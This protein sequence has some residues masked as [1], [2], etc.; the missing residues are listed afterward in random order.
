[1]QVALIGV[2]ISEW[3]KCIVKELYNVYVYQVREMC[4]ESKCLT[5]RKNEPNNYVVRQKGWGKYRLMKLEGRKQ[6]ADNRE[7]GGEKEKC[8]IKISIEKDKNIGR[9]CGR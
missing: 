4:C 8:E 5:L 3:P 2:F 1:M 9:S 7:R 6:G